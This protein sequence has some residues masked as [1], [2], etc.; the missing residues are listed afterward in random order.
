ML[1]A[2]DLTIRLNAADDVVI[3]RAELPGGTEIIKEK[4]R[5]AVTIPAGHKIATRALKPGDPVRRYNQIIGFATQPISPGDH[6]HVHNLA[7]GDFERDYAFGADYVPTEFVAEP[8]TFMGIKRDDCRVAT[9]NYLGVI[10][11]VN[12][13]AHVCRLIA[14]HFDDDFMAQYPNV[15]GVVPIHHRTGCGMGA[16]G[17]PIEVLRR[18]LGG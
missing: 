4:V 18:T 12:C 3:A 17:E 14:K 8:A 1:Q 15:D 7:M 9:R 2:A 16:D 11:S 6:V 5:A 13:S 10:S